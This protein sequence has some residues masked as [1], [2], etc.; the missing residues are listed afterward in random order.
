MNTFIPSTLSGDPYDSQDDSLNQDIYNENMEFATEV[1][2]H[3]CN[4]SGHICL[5]GQVWLSIHICLDKY[6]FLD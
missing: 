1:Y 4:S 2:I 5:S 6:D 3:C